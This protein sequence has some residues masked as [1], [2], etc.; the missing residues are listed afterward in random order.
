MT[1]RVEPAATAPAL[2]T[3]WYL[4]RLIAGK[5]TALIVAAVAVLDPQ[6]AENAAQARIVAMARP[7]RMWPTQM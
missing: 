1:P 6:I 2:S 7:P 3:G 4:Y 5:A